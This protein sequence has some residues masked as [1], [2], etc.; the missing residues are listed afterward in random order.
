MRKH[1]YLAGSFSRL[2]QIQACAEDLRLRGYT[3]DCR[4]L[5]GP[6]Q[7]HPGAEK[8]ESAKDTMPPEAVLFAKDDVEDLYKADAIICFTESPALKV[9]RGGRHVELGMAIAWG[10]EIH[11]VGPRENVFCCL[12]EVKVHASW[13]E[14]LSWLRCGLEIFNN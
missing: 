14:F 4:W 12:P 2:E 9:G 10:K 3:V 13:E 11:I 8:V 6:H 5:Q 1:F 7:V